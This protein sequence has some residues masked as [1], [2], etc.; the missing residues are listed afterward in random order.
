M[1][2]KMRRTARMNIWK[3]RNKN[4][5]LN[6]NRKMRTHIL[7]ILA[8]KLFRMLKVVFN[9][10]INKMMMMRK[11]KMMKNMKKMSMIRQCTMQLNLS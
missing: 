8:V 2:I 6:T 9:K 7:L 4:S 10:T 1:M 3:F 11:K 5:K